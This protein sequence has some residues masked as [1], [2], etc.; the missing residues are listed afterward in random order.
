[1]VTYLYLMA[2]SSCVCVISRGVSSNYPLFE[3][4]RFSLHSEWNDVDSGAGG[5]E[6]DE[7]DEE[8]AR[9]ARP[10]PQRLTEAEGGGGRRLERGGQVILA[11]LASNMYFVERVRCSFLMTIIGHSFRLDDST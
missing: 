2:Y 6:A 7:D 4:L 1:M 10:Q 8:Q 9:L 3:T 11:G 5:A